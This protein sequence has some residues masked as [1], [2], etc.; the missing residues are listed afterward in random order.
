MALALVLPSPATDAAF[1]VIFGIFV[2]AMLTLAV[3][4]VLWAVR[5]DRAGR[6]AWVARHHQDIA[7]DD[8]ATTDGHPGS[9]ATS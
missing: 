6:A 3:V 4:V 1:F 5:R 9:G 8:R 2:V 7:G